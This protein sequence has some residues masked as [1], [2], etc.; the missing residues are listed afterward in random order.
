M[1]N[2]MIKWSLFIGGIITSVIR[3]YRSFGKEYERESF[4]DIVKPSTIVLIS[5]WYDSRNGM[6]QMELI[7]AI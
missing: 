6:R 7:R 3:L 5:Q 4:C 2:G 1:I